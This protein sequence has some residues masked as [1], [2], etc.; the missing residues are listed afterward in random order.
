M[1]LK[2]TIQ[3]DMKDAMRASDKGRLS[4]LRMLL[5]SIQRREIEDRVDDLDDGLVLGV[6]EKQVK[7]LKDSAKQYADNGREDRAAAE[8]AEVDTLQVYLPEQL[9]D[10]ELDA[11]LDE[12]IAAT[13]AS[14]MQDMG[15]V[16]GQLKTKA[17]GRADM[18]A[19]SSKVKA[20]L[21]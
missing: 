6:I 7:Q 4:T 9:S 13:G 3:S 10:E 18:G 1:T 14:G 15:K 17:Q 16:M 2:Q 8:L 5:A 12:V 20:R 21:A 19:L 11:M